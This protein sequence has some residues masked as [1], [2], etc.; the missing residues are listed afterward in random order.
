MTDRIVV[1]PVLPVHDMTAALDFWR[2]L[3]FEVESY[4][5]G[6]AW[7][8]NGGQELLHLAATDGL[9]PTRNRTAV[10]LHVQDA[11]AWHRRWAETDVAVT[12]LVDQPWGMR[13]FRTHDP[14]GNLVRVGQNVD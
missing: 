14:S 9:D 10:H 7:V 12:P 2:R 4:D 6:Y 8:R 13:E 1:R 3:G 11:S 5:D